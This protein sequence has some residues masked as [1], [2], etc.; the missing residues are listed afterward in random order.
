[1]WR[2][3]MKRGA[4]RIFSK[5]VLKASGGMQTT[6]SAADRELTLFKCFKIFTAFLTLLGCFA[7]L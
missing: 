3:V 7:K 4:N 6:R 1:M 2:A 5:G